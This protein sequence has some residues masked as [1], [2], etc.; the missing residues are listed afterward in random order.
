MWVSSIEVP[1]SVSL[2]DI[3]DGITAGQLAAGIFQDLHLCIFS[4][5]CP[6]DVYILFGFQDMGHVAVFIPLLK[7]R[8]LS[9]CG[10]YL[11]VYGII[12]FRGLFDGINLIIFKPHHPS[13]TLRVSLTAIGDD[14]GPLE[15]KVPVQGGPRWF[16]YSRT[17]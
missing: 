4:I 8:V 13:H 5:C 11:D 16:F 7:G 6:D 17:R 10:I 14:K 1:A 3:L 15:S 2:I 12:R 9:L